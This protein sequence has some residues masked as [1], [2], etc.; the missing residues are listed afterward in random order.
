MWVAQMRGDIDVHCNTALTPPLM[1][2]IKEGSFRVLAVIGDRPVKYLIDVPTTDQLGYNFRVLPLLRPILAPPNTP[3]EIVSALQDI[4]S[5]SLV[6]PDFRKWAK[7][8]PQML[9]SP[10]SGKETRQMIVDCVQF[11]EKYKK[12]IEASL[13]RFK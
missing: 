8:Q 7:D 4:L 9:D 2:Q 5:K 6:S 12:A 3:P 11:V 13:A 10:Q 1:A